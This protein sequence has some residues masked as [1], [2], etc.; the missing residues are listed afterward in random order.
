MARIEESSRKI[1]DIISVIDDRG[2]PDEPAGPF[3]GDRSGEG[4]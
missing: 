3:G 4:G 2:R 1:S